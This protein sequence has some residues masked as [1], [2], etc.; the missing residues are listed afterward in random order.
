MKRATAF[1]HYGAD[2]LPMLDDHGVAVRVV[3]GELMGVKAPTETAWPTLYADAC[4]PPG[5]RMPLDATYEERGDLHLKGDSGPLPATR[6][7][8]DSCSVCSNPATRSP[9]RRSPM[10]AS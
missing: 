9:S 1:I 8:R 6:S 4:W 5:Q 2:E 10:H 3:A 7:A